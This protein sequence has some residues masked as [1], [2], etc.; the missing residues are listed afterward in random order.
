[1]NSAHIKIQSKKEMKQFAISVAK[2]MI[3]PN[4]I[5]LDGELGSGKTFWVKQFT[6]YFQDKKNPIMVQSP[7]Y[8]YLNIYPTE[9]RIYHFDFYRLE[10]IE[11]FHLL[12]LSEH[13]GSGISL[14]EWYQ[15]IPMFDLKEHLSIFIKSNTSKNSQYRDI[16]IQGFGRSEKIVQAIAN[17]FSKL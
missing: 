6:T 7:T 10:S 12:G 13:I 2:K 14:I 3:I 4:I 9:P 8:S 17:E 11:Q 1:M 15:K 16:L 5:T